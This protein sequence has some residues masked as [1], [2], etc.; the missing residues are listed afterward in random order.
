MGAGFVVALLF[1]AILLDRWLP[2]DRWLTGLGTLLMVISA[3][4]LV[5]QRL[6]GVAPALASTVAAAL[7]IASVPFEFDAAILFVLMFALPA[8]F[9]GEAMVRGH[10]LRRGCVWAFL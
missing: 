9:V 1:S 10:G 8:W 6:M 3:F 2:A 5:I 7:L 4:P